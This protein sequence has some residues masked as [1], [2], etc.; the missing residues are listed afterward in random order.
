[1]QMVAPYSSDAAIMNAPTCSSAHAAMRCIDDI[2]QTVNLSFGRNDT[3]T[4]T[5]TSDLGPH[6]AGVNANID[7]GTVDLLPSYPLNVDHPLLSVNGNHL[8]FSALHLPTHIHE[9]KQ[10]SAAW[11]LRPVVA[12]CSASA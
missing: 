1:M 6:L 3:M 7:C 9:L 4:A 2:Q 12:H 8:A 11:K 5:L 10:P